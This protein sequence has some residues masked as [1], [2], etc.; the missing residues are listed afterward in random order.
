[1]CWLALLRYYSRQVELKKEQEKTA[2]SLLARYSGQGMRFAFYQ[3]FPRALRRP[4][5]LED[6]VFLEYVTNPE[7]TVTQYHRIRGR[8]A[9]YEQELMKDCFEGIHVKEF[10]LFYGEEL[11]CY[12]EETAADGT[13]KKS[14]IRVLQ[15]GKRIPGGIW[16]VPDAEPYDPGRAGGKYRGPETGTGKLPPA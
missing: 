13:V 5:Q 6:K 8:Q 11:E 4:Y 16:P 3:K 15:A 2:A 7:N 9:E 14:G 1:M 12:T 10:I